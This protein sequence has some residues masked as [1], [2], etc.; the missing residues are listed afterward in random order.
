MTKLSLGKFF[1]RKAG[2]AKIREADRR[3]DGS[4]V[5]A[6]LQ[7]EVASILRGAEKLRKRTDKALDDCG[8]PPRTLGLGVSI[9]RYASHEA[10]MRFRRKLVEAGWVRE[11]LSIAEDLGVAV[12][13]HEL[14]VLAKV[15]SSCEELKLLRSEAFRNQCADAATFI[16]QKMEELR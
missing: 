2:A 4:E 9:C 3:N 14:R 15:T 7:S 12:T 8:A 11:V 13:N 6:K 5:V 10:R 1:K 16:Q